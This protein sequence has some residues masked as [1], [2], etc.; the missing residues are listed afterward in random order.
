MQVDCYLHVRVHV[1]VGQLPH[2]GHYV[3]FCSCQLN[4]ANLIQRKC[5]TDTKFVDVH[6]VRLI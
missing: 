4:A 5:E 2:M 6:K 1:S 3:R